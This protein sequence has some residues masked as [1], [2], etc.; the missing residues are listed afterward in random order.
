[1]D[2]REVFDQLR[3]YYT[4]NVKPFEHLPEVIEAAIQVIE[5]DLPAARKELEGLSTFVRD[6][7]ASVPDVETEVAAA[8]G[9][10][11]AALD[12]AA[13]VE[14][15]CQERVTVAQQA[16]ESQTTQLTRDFEH[17]GATL[18][19]DYT[20]RR[21]AIEQEILVLE[22]TKRDLEIDLAALKAK[23]A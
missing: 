4:K 16:A 19:R 6:L 21:A 20:T 15:R 3:T 11:Q 14:Q 2:I 13:L 5:H 23:F 22:K 18:E 10:V 12:E 8:K 9:R 17:K 7:R 1:M